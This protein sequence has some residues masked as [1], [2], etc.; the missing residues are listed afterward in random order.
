MW[1][2]RTRTAQPGGDERPTAGVD[3]GS[4]QPARAWNRESAKLRCIGKAIR[5]AQAEGVFG[6][7]IKLSVIDGPD[8]ADYIE[9]LENGLQAL[10][11]IVG[12][13][14]IA[15]TGAFEESEL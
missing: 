13:D 14:F 11:A 15:A 8:E 9:A 12:F 2:T 4:G 10:G 3:R 5:Q 1:V 6:V 7:G